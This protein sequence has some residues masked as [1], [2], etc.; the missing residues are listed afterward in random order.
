MPGSDKTTA[1]LESLVCEWRDAREKWF[2]VMNNEAI[3]MDRTIVLSRLGKAEQALM[4]Y[5]KSLD[6]L[7][8][9][10]P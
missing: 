7:T 8:Y 9:S 3:K 5:A 1:A 4:E 2:S 10:R 6:D